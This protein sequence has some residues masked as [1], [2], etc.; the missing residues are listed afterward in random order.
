MFKK[1]KLGCVTKN[2][3]LKNKVK[4]KALLVISDIHFCLKS[5]II[6]YFFVST[7]LL[8][9]ST[10]FNKWTKTSVLYKKYSDEKSYGQQNQVS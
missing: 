10:E 6:L 7:Y 1:L 5:L 4:T 8:N 2:Q 9:V 3:Q